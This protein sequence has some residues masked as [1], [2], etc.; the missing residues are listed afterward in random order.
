MEP[1][2]SDGDW[3]I[4]EKK[5]KLPQDWIPDRYDVVIIFDKEHNDK[6]TKRVI[7]LAGDIV[8]IKEGVIHL[9]ENELTEPFSRGKILFYICDG[10]GNNL[11]YWSGPDIGKPVVKLVDEKI[12]KIPEGYVWVIG[13]NREVTWYGLLK[14]KD[15]EGL[16]IL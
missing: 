1:S 9:N 12:K 14:I 7:G 2:Y 10:D 3:I 13:D 5:E 6:L 15:I 16:V 8:E 4:V 11:K